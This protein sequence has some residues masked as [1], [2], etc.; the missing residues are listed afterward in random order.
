MRSSSGPETSMHR[1]AHARLDRLRIGDPARESADRVRQRRRRKRRAAHQMR[2][3]RRHAAAG[4]AAADRVAGAAA[5]LEQSASPLRHL[6][7]ARRRRRLDLRFL[8]KLGTRPAI[9]RPAGSPYARAASRRTRCT[10]RDTCRACRPAARSRWS[11]PGW[12][13]SCRPARA[14]RRSGS[15]RRWPSR[16]CTGWPVGMWISLAVVKTREGSRSR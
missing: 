9:A 8:P 15:R 7:R 14:P 5:I 1:H 11:G 13:R 6:G 4:L 3:V 2:E 16:I 12:C 10:G